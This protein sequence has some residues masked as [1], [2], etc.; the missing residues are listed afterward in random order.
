M[1]QLPTRPPARRWR[2][3][4]PALLSLA[5]TLGGCTGVVFQPEPGHRATPAAAGIPYRDVRFTAA[6][7][8]PLHGWFLPAAGGSGARGTIVQAHG[9][10]ENIS[11]HIASVAWLRAHGY[12]VFAF[13]YR[14]YGRSRGRPSMPGVHR[15]TAAALDAADRL[16]TLPRGR[17]VLLGQSLG[18]AVAVVVAARLPA[19]RAPGA[20][21]ADSAPR[22]YRAVARE[23]LAGSWLTWPLQVPL[24]WLITAEYAA[25]EA[26]GDLPPIPKL[27]IGNERDPV[28]PFAHAQRLHAAATPP[29]ECWRLARDGHVTTFASPRL[30]QAFLAWLEDALAGA[31]RAPHGGTA[32]CRRMPG[33][34]AT[35]AAGDDPAT[36]EAAWQ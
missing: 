32:T 24:S 14:G 30:R 12:N 22:S 17:L 36:G 1:A 5:L 10:A 6:D 13:D 18:G 34:G 7:G 11:T 31:D 35:G 23:Q 4:A 27:F 9:N 26:A 33:D 28:I 3:A 2:R 15:D 16:D 19:A 29:A 8:V 20:L 25:A 21:V